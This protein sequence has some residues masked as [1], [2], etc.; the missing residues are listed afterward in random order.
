[1]QQLAVVGGLVQQPL[2]A[3][4]GVLA[5]AGAAKSGHGAWVAGGMVMLVLTLIATRNLAARIRQVTRRPFKR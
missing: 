5:G 1:M 3:V 2:M 4:L